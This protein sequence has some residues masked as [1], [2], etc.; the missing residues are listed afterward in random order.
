MRLVALTIPMVFLPLLNGCGLVF[1]PTVQQYPGPV[2]AVRIGDAHSEE[3]L[4]DAQV[5]FE[6]VKYVNWIRYP[7]GLSPTEPD[8]TSP[9]TST[10]DED[11]VILD[12][13]S[14]KAG[15]FTFRRKS[16]WGAMQ[17]W[18]PLPPILGPAILHEHRAYILASA[19]GH[20]QLI[21]QYSPAYPPTPGAKFSLPDPRHGRATFDDSGMLTIYLGKAV[22]EPYTTTC[23]RWLKNWRG[24]RK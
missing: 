19:P 5:R 7:P 18:L 11:V 8:Y 10:K 17:I 2:K 9:G 23:P 4:T 13:T 15:R 16:M 22:R 21:F 24:G 1:V 12:Q 6:I 3:I 14:D 20:C